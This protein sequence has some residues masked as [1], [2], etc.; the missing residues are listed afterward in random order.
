MKKTEFNQI[1][2]SIDK[3]GRE[4]FRAF[5]LNKLRQSITLMKSVNL[6]KKQR[7][8][9]FKKYNELIKNYPPTAKKGSL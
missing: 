6:N 4:L 1:L 3:I 5:E 2:N 8:Y 7:K 9:M